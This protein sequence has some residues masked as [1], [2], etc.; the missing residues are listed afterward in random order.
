M[1]KLPIVSI[2]SLSIALYLGND[3]AIKLCVIMLIYNVIVHSKK[4]NLENL[5]SCSET[6]TDN[7]CNII[8]EGIGTFKCTKSQTSSDVNQDP[9]ECKSSDELFSH[10]NKN[11]CLDIS[12]E[13]NT[14]KSLISD[15]Q[16][17][18]Y[19]MIKPCKE[20]AISCLM[21]KNESL[22]KTDKTEKL[23]KRINTNNFIESQP[24]TLNNRKFNEISTIR[25]FRG[26]EIIVF[27]EINFAGA[28]H[29][30]PEYDIVNNVKNTKMFQD[31]DV[32]TSFN[33]KTNPAFPNGIN[34]IK[35]NKLATANYAI[36][37]NVAKPVMS[38]SD[39]Y[40]SNNDE[41]SEFPF[42]DCITK[43]NSE[44]NCKWFQITNENS[45]NTPQCQLG[46]K[47]PEAAGPSG[48]VGNT[49]IQIGSQFNN[50]PN[51]DTNIYI[52]KP[53]HYT[54]YLNRESSSITKMVSGQTTLIDAIDVC[55]LDQECAGIQYSSEN[56]SDVDKIGEYKVLSFNEIDNAL[57]TYSRNGKWDIYA[58]KHIDKKDE[59][60]FRLKI[61]NDIKTKYDAVNG[62]VNDTNEYVKSSTITDKY[63]TD[64]KLITD[65]NQNI[66]HNEIVNYQSS[67][68]II[69]FTDLNTNGH[70]LE[71]KFNDSIKISNLSIFGKVNSGSSGDVSEQINF[72]NKPE[73]ET[74]LNYKTV[75]LS[76]NCD[77]S[78]INKCDEVTTYNNL[79]DNLMCTY[80]ELIPNNDNEIYLKC[81]FITNDVNKTPINVT[82]NSIQITIFDPTLK[83]CNSRLKYT[84]NSNIYPINV[85]VK[86][87]PYTD[88]GKYNIISSFEKKSLHD[89]IQQLTKF[90]EI[91]VDI[92]KSKIFNHNFD[93][94][95]SNMFNGW[96]RKNGNP[97]EDSDD[98]YCRFVNSEDS[99]ELKCSHFDGQQNE[100]IYST[101]QILKNNI[102]T[103][104]FTNHIK[105]GDNKLC[106][107]INPKS[108]YSKSNKIGCYTFK[109]DVGDN[110]KPINTLSQELQSIHNLPNS[111][112]C[113]EMTKP[114]LKKLLS[115][116]VIQYCGDVV[117]GD[118]VETK[119]L[120]QFKNNNNNKIDAGFWLNNN[121]YLFKN[122][123]MNGKPVVLYSVF[124]NDIQKPFT[125]IVCENTFPGLTFSDINERLDRID[126][127]FVL[128]H[129]DKIVYFFR[130]DPSTKDCKVIKYNMD[131][132]SIE[133]SKN[134]ESYPILAK[135]EFK[136][137]GT[138]SNI[139]SK[140]TGATRAVSI[141]SGN[142]NMCYFFFSG[143]FMTFDLNLLTTGQVTINNKLRFIQNKDEIFNNVPF[144]QVTC[145]ISGKNVSGKNYSNSIYLFNNNYCIKVNLS[146]NAKKDDNPQSEISYIW[147]DI[148]KLDHN[149]LI[150]NPVKSEP[151]TCIIPGR[152]DKE[153][154][155]QRIQN[156]QEEERIV[157][158]EKVKL[159]AAA[160]DKLIANAAVVAVAETKRLNDQSAINIERSHMQNLK[161]RLDDELLP[162]DDRAKL[163]AQL[164][165]SKENIKENIKELLNVDPGDCQDPE[166]C[167]KLYD[168]TTLSSKTKQAADTGSRSIHFDQHQTFNT[169][170]AEYE[171][172]LKDMK[173]DQKSLKENR[174]VQQQLTDSKLQQLEM[175]FQSQS[176]VPE[177]PEIPGIP[178]VSGVPGVSGSTLTPGSS[179]YTQVSNK[180]MGDLLKNKSYEQDSSKEF[181]DKHGKLNYQ[182]STGLPTI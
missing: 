121:Y 88:T 86:N 8:K 115:T 1:I 87:I 91:P 126:A 144:S 182:I 18:R 71:I 89:N 133:C 68:H 173:D 99:Y 164:E 63:P 3:I 72:I 122:S 155:M 65:N 109:Q 92:T 138:N 120:D 66:I 176:P 154:E 174:E 37:P 137:I 21:D 22:D 179:Q 116:D 52:K 114:D 13:Y 149:N 16:D 90:P 70:L 158:A 163:E 150:K 55:D 156:L 84:E 100:T 77:S 139:F 14:D 171:K 43:C 103:N 10:Q 49:S 40:S 170:I 104:Y 36:Y 162:D 69:N 15:T 166:D 73:S 153:R 160:S 96:I 23:N 45:V 24:N 157:N 111:Q 127:S 113:S 102:G 64:T 130:I 118:S 57:N 62:T 17:P 5:E 25:L 39:M 33:D 27:A 11:V 95:D 35:I 81:K 159:A 38:G 34:S 132:Y 123:T 169:R 141:G 119:K 42:S 125:S 67:K 98:T 117:S 20:I 110:N 83:L 12:Q 28:S 53:L 4:E 146:P 180:C 101:N 167:D 58:K 44:S 108:T 48:K 61:G 131:K 152:M 175:R 6:N 31:I 151:I 136:L 124:D 60:H 7:E 19:N 47:E 148:W 181:I 46:I 9:Y 93:I 2:L 78:P 79:R 59:N 32:L 76:S 97:A 134:S 56:T 106:Y 105:G 161:T 177:I 50:S 54:Q 147:E 140:L 112:I 41:N 165:A 135:D 143:Q 94:G 172:L 82:I 178:G 85:V 129:T 74:N 51:N 29:I 26:Y 168:T 75:L 128:D 80:Y 30:Y 142:S 145:A 107:C